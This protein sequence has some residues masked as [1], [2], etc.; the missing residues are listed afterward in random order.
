MFPVLPRVPAP[1]AA[2][3]S[4]DAVW[5]QTDG[6]ARVHLLFERKM[7]IMKIVLILVLL[8]LAGC[9][10]ID[11]LTAT[12]G[13]ALTAGSVAVIHRTPVD[14]VYSLAT[15]RDCSGVRL[16]EGKSYCRHEE[17]APE[18]AAFCTR[19]LAG[20]DCGRDPS[21]LAGQYRGVADAP[22]MTP[23]QQANRVPHWP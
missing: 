10:V 17:P 21:K 9:G 18:P 1:A 3:H 14:A 2:D 15:D 12:V 11:N 5:P 8:P 7:G 16:D 4:G 6:S 19:A 23:E 20:V 22:A 13:V